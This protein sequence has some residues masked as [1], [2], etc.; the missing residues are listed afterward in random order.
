[1]E[2]KKL[3]LAVAI[4]SA[5]LTACGGGGGSST[6]AT[7]TTYTVSGTAAKGIIQHGIVT[8][9]EYV[10]QNWSTVGSATTD[11]QGNYTLALTNYSGGPL[12]IEIT[13]DANTTMKC[14]NVAGCGNSSTFGSPIALTSDF[15]MAA[16]LPSVSTTTLSNVPVTPYTNMAAHKAETALT[17]TTS[18]TERTAAVNNAL[19]QVTSLV[20][21]NVATTPAVDITA[22]NFSSTATVDEQRAAAMSAALMKFTSDSTN[23]AAVVSQLGTALEDGKIDSTDA[24]SPTQLQQAWSDTIT[25]PTMKT[26]LSSDT[27]AA[28]TN[29]A[30][31][32]TQNTAEDGSL[33]PVVSDNYGDTDVA[34]AKTLI[35]DT[36]SLVYDIVN[37]DFKT[38][39]DALGSNADQAVQVF[40][41][42]S[43]A[44]ASLLGLAVDQ[45]ITQLINNQQVHL[46]GSFP[47]DIKSGA[48]TLGTLTLTTTNTSAGLSAVLSGSLKGT[49]PD[50]RTITVNNLTLST[51]LSFDEINYAKTDKTQYTVNISGGI[52]D[53][54]TSMS[55]SNGQAQ[56]TFASTLTDTTGDNLGNALTAIELKNMDL[57]LQANGATFAGNAKFKLVKPDFTKVSKALYDSLPLTLKSVALSGDFTTSDS[58][59]I[60]ASVGLDLANSETFDLMAYLNSENT[61]WVYKENA[62]D[63]TTIAQL[64]AL[65]SIPSTAQNWNINYG[66]NQWTGSS[67]YTAGYSYSDFDAN[68]MWIDGNS[69]YDNTVDSYNAYAAVYNP[70]TALN[71]IIATDYASIPGS[72][73]TSAYVNL[74]YGTY[75]DNNNQP[76][77]YSNNNLYGEIQLGDYKESAEQF[78]NVT[79]NTAF[80]MTN[81][82]G[83]PH[84]KVSAVV[85]RNAFKGG[86]ASLLVNWD[87][88]QYTINLDNV[89]LDKQTGSITVTAPTGTSLVLKDVAVA[90]HSA[91]G[92]LYVGTKKVADVATLNNGAVKVSYIDGTF[93]TLQ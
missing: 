62:L 45:M 24:I 91:T 83:L 34:K 84:A 50:A 47:V 86:S 26:L 70:T 53:G 85:N 37:T 56:A 81:V 36:R 54:S 8:A 55:V 75:T 4:S 27:Q 43:A 2:F 79:A 39:L 10:N 71:N 69:Q 78:L 82:T 52:S 46:G 13:A 22:N 12:K 65:K 64:K 25:D 14:D 42:D 20:G 73:V 21:F 89:D 16:I 67:Y 3:T 9:K 5:L 19:S 15:S 68:G 58:Q 87:T 7:P 48:D 93:E 72:T 57:S 28:I 59:D 38:P 1:M 41:K 44:M 29:Q 76:M 66:N 51:D 33:T 80:E 63:A 49:E 74:S 31:Y 60:K 6:S 90:D 18:A 77:T 92:A 32:I 88:K 11:D 17:A 35:T 23:V 61:V 30:S 40:D